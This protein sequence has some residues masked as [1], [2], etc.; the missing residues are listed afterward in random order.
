MKFILAKIYFRLAMKASAMQDR[1]RNI[2]DNLEVKA[3]KLGGKKLEDWIN[4][5]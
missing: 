3:F 1:I 2:Q 4:N 5:E